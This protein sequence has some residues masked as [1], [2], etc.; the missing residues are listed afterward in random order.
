MTAADRVKTICKVI[1]FVLVL[2]MVLLIVSKI[3]VPFNRQDTNQAKTFYRLEKNTVDTLIVGSSTLLVGVSPLQMWEDHGIVA[4]TWANS[5]Q[6]PEITY[7]NVKEAF[8]YQKP[9]LVI[10]GITSLFQEYDVDANEA[11]LRRGMD[12]HKLSPEKLAT[13]R[14]ITSRSVGG[15]LTGGEKQSYL[16]YVFPLLRY[17]SRW[18]DIGKYQEDKSVYTY[19][20]YHYDYMHGQF[21]IYRTEKVK[22]RT[23]VDPDAKPEEICETSWKFY[24]KTIDLCRDNGADVLVVVYPDSWWNTGRHLTAVKLFEEEGVDFL[25]LNE[26][27]KFEAAGLDW[28]TDFYNPRHLNPVGANKAT[29]YLGKYIVKRYDLPQWKCSD[30][31]RRQYDEDLARYKK[32]VADFQKKRGY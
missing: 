31:V 32:D 10:I 2:A 12:F 11:F 16:S 22:P 15:E 8:Q 29:K 9:K 7:L 26:D 23:L 3:F 30:K 21:A 6:A 13:I 25:D 17:H 28:D 1:I 14:D 27:A 4:H 20:N 24:K 5:T 19:Y 18:K